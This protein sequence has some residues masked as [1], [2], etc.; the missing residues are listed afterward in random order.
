[1]VNKLEVYKSNQSH[2]EKQT[3]YEAKLNDLI[4]FGLGNSI[5]A[6]KCK[7]MALYHRLVISE[8]KYL[9]ELI[10]EASKRRLY[11]IAE[12]KIH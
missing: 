5:D 4:K 8:Q 6:K 9:N 12:L 7:L 3:E 2:L 11:T 1:M 10:S